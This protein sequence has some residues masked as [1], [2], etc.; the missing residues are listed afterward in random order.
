VKGVDKLMD[1]KPPPQQDTAALMAAQTDRARELMAVAKEL[2]SAGDK[3]TAEMMRA[4]AISML[5]GDGDKP[6][7]SAQTKASGGASEP[8]ELSSY[9]SASDDDCSE[10]QSPPFKRSKRNRRGKS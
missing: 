1:V 8:D 5:L 3:S 9:S 7:P 10:A 4:K 6:G 2:E